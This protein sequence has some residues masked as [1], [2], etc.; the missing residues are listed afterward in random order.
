MPSKKKREIR[1]RRQKTG[2]S[3]QAAQ[4]Q[5]KQANTPLQPHTPEWLDKLTAV[6]EGQAEHSKLIFELSDST[7]VCAVCGDTPTTLYRS[8][9]AAV[10]VSLVLLCDD[11]F[12][13]QTTRMGAKLV[14]AGGSK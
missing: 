2:E 6:N 4:R 8:T 7:D 13:I 5:W 3:Y 1:E 14:L 11:C 12:V 10:A 9:E